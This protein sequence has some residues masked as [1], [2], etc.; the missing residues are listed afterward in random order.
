MDPK[1]AAR[2]LMGGKK[3]RRKAAP[4]GGQIQGANRISNDDA[5]KMLL[6]ALRVEIPNGPPADFPEAAKSSRG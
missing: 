1:D 4:S 3:A 6:G 2:A 5:E